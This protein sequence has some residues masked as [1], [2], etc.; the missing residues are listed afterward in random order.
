[1]NSTL[2][3]FLNADPEELFHTGRFVV[4][5]L[6][7]DE[8]EHGSPL[9]ES[10]DIVLACW[11][12]CEADGTVVKRG[13]KFGGIYEQQELIDDLLSVQFAVAQ[14]AK[15]DLG[16]MRRCGLELRDV[17]AYDP[18]LA[19]WVLD[20]NQNLPRSLN[21]LA[22]K[23]GVPGKADLVSLLIKLGVPARDIH[24]RWLLE[25]CGQDVQTTLDVFLKQREEVSR[26]SV[27][28]LA[29]V[30]FLTCSVL[31]DIEFEGLILDSQAV[32]EEYNNVADSVDT[33]GKE[34]A[35]LTGGINLGSP[36][37]LAAFLYD[38][39]GVKEAR[40]HK[41]DIIKT[42]G[43]DPSANAKTLALLKPATEPQR[44][45][46]SKYKDY[47]KQVSLLEKNLDYFKLTCEHRLG[48]F[49]GRFQQNV[50]KTHRLAS[51]GIPTLFPGLKKAKSVQLQNIPR[52]YKRLFWSGDEDWV[53]FEADGSQLE[54][55]VAAD[56]GHDPVALEEIESGADV[57]S[58]SAQVMTEAG[59]PTSRQE[60]KAVTFRPL[61]GGGSGSD[62]LRA[63]C[64][65]FK[66]KYKGI[67]DTQRGWAVHTADRKQ[68]TTPYGMTFFFP[69]CKMQR[70]GYI[71]D[72]T[73]IYNF[74]I[75]GFA[76]GEIIPIALVYFWHRTRG[77]PIHIFATIHDSIAA[78]VHKDV[79]EETK[80]IAK[81]CLT[82]DV[83]RFLERVYGYCFKVPLGLGI[84]VSRNWG[85]TKEE[86]S[87][88]VW[89]D[90]REVKVK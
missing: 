68:F 69:D 55:R 11:V 90:G 36:K 65:F 40:D 23:Y 37:Q 32:V 29:F 46:L 34:L 19:Q 22:R 9:L 47:N 35:E 7:T 18:M 51:N 1:M 88:N 5:D 45:F 82:T 85:Y 60:A 38:K 33:L 66:Q 84:K 83:Y 4:F 26:R 59:E 3:W 76:T 80:Q 89:P 53:V 6:E 71:T 24:P 54:F 63:Y 30:R 79:V 28:H 25:Y 56:L 61:F 12:V 62:A 20:G 13:H 50:V 74:P 57:H 39:L 70:S 72:T 17:L 64:E 42:K 8:E 41:G 77:M 43:G 10:N 67:S 15:F 14:N 21:A 16:W 75:Q 48:K 58:I 27:W 52:E 87:W 78:R 73:S 31:T 86:D 49:H 81:Q 2:P 44:V